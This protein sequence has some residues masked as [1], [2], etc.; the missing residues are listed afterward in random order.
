MLDWAKRKIDIVR[1]TDSSSVINHICDRLLAPGWNTF[2]WY[3]RKDNNDICTDD[4]DVYFHTPTPVKKGAI[5]V[6]YGD[7]I[8]NL[9]CNP[10]RILSLSDEAAL[11]SY[12]VAYDAN[13]TITVTGPDSFKL[14]D[15]VT[16]TPANNPQHVVLHGTSN[17]SAGVYLSKEGV[18]KIE[19]EVKVGGMIEKHYRSI[20]VYR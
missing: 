17:N 7:L 3:G 13:V 12:D 15:N 19:V 16:Q 9:S 8:S 11:I 18:Y 1:D 5:L 10:Y 20:T 4:W 2:Y 14:L 6:Y